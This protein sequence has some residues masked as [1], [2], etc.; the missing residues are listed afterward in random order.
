MGR[1]YGHFRC[2]LTSILLCFYRSD[3]C[4]PWGITSSPT[5]R[6]VGR[7][8]L[9]QVSFRGPRDGQE[10][11]SEPRRHSWGLLLTIVPFSAGL[12]SGR[13]HLIPWI[14][15]SLHF[16]PLLYALKKTAQS[17][18]LWVLGEISPCGESAADQ[19]EGEEWGWG[20]LPRLLPWGVVANW[21]HFSTEDPSSSET[22]LSKFW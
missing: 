7:V 15:H 1:K 21:L 18:V 20:I 19:R 11:Q 10:T 16:S 2:H 8:G 22:A 4:F 3:F 5:L 13:M 17:K 9:T 12:E 14:I 6:C